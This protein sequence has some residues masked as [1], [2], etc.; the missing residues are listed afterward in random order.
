MSAEKKNAAVSGGGTSA[1]PPQMNKTPIVIALVLSLVLV[2]G[3]LV[4]ARV[5]LGPAGQIQ[6]AM[7]TLPAPD[8][9][10]A[11]CAALVDNLPDKAFGHTRARIAE[12][13]PAGTAAWASS[14]LE[15]VTVRCGVDMPFQYTTLADTV[16]VDGIT[17]LPVADITAGSSLKTWYSV[18]RF[19]VVAITADD[20]STEHAVNPVEPFTTALADL[21]QREGEPYPAP[22]SQLATADTA[23]IARCT[24]LLDALPTSLQVGSQDAPVVY[25]LIDDATMSAA[26]YTSEAVAWGAAGLEPVVIRCGVA[27]SESYAAGAVLQQINDIPWFEDTILASGT[28]SATWYALGRE[29]DVAVSLPQY[30]GGALIQ[31]SELIEEYLPAS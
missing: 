11:E 6:V 23:D 2:A 20:L 25:D 29:A 9:D 24:E 28:T 3:V 31:L 19:P 27:P 10:S 30:A 26:G 15:R 21:P 4:G 18:D 22:L 17:W 13:V 5:L 12:P 1:V 8:A 14:E 16:A 7:S